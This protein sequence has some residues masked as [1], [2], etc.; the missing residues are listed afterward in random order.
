VFESERH[1]IIL[2]LVEERSVISV[3]ELVEFLGASE[4]TIR[5]DITAMAG[6]GELRRVRGGAEAL[7]PRHRGHLSATHFAAEEKV[8][9]GEKRAIARAA[10]AMVEDGDS[11]IINGGT[12]T[13]RLVEFLGERKLDIMTNSV[14]IAVD[15]MKNGRHRITIPG[16]TIYPQQGIVL[17]PFSHEIKMHFWGRSLFSGC[18]GLSKSGMM[19]TDPL[20][21]EAEMMLLE[22]ADRLVVMADSRKLRRCSSMIVVP[23][24]RITTVITD[25]GAS[26][27][28]LDMLRAAG[29]ETVVVDADE[30]AVE[31]NAAASLRA[32]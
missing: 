7:R 17:S 20:V 9:F 18:Y 6:R 4:A 2:S 19:E 30:N 28:D 32:I 22:C 21:V 11:I 12:T 29:L 25:S 14:P 10:A 1:R 13:Y 31:S 24:S 15:L 16:G 27:E 26:A 23:L 5:R 8:C 3:T